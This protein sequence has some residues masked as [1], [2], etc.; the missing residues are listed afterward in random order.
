[1]YNEA[2]AKNTTAYQ[3][4]K[5]CQR[6]PWMNWNTAKKCMEENGK[7]EA[8]INRIGKAWIQRALVKMTLKKNRVRLPH[9][10]IAK[11]IEK[12]NSN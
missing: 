11:L 6:K 12:M 3:L 4:L 9:K 7:D 10:T 2:K 5:Q 1:M 8:T